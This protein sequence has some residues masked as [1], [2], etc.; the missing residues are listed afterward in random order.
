MKETIL[1]RI[2]KSYYKLLILID[3]EDEILSTGLKE[4][5]NK[6]LSNSFLS[7]N[8]GS[9]YMQGDFYSKNAII[10]VKNNDLTNLIYE[11]MVPKSKYIQ[12]PCEEKAKKNE[13]T[14]KF[15][16]NLLNKY[17]KIA[18]ITKDEDNSLTTQIMPKNWDKENIFLRYQ[19][20]NI[21]L[22]QTP[23]LSNEQRWDRGL[24]IIK[25]GRLIKNTNGNVGK[26]NS[27]DKGIVIINNGTEKLYSI[28]ED[29]LN[30]IYDGWIIE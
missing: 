24:N 17:W 8:S 28:D 7:L 19:E 11:H 6:F 4:G 18:I 2:A 9:K 3:W 13:L 29:I 26:L 5:L 22:I 20:S 16:V 1:Q 30:I 12:K 25:N 23:F 10:K 14:I 21:K 15:I 27:N